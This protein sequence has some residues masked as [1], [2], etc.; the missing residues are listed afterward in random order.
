MINHWNSLDITGN[1][2]TFRQ[3]GVGIGMSRMPTEMDLQLPGLKV[4]LSL[5]EAFTQAV[6]MVLGKSASG[7]LGAS[8]L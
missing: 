5:S 6:M 4:F 3:T 8:R 1:W 7:N 2:V